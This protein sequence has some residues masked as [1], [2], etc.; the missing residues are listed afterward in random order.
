MKFD[1]RF[2]QH[3][4]KFK[5]FDQNNFFDDK[6]R[7]IEVLES[8]THNH[9]SGP[10]F[11]N[12]KVK[13]EDTVWAG[14][15][16]VH[17]NSSD[18]KK[19][20]HHNDK[21]YDNVI[22][23]VVYKNDCQVIRT[24]GQEIPTAELKIQ[25]RLMNDYDSLIQS[26]RQIACSDSILAV[27]NFVINS[28]LS[29]VLFERMQAKTDL[30][31]LI[32]EQNKNDWEEAFYTMTARAFGF[33]VNADPFELLSKSVSQKILSK[34]KNSVFQIEALL[35]GQSGFLEKDIT[36]DQYFKD[37]QKEYKFLRAKYNLK[38]IEE[39]L[40]KFMRLRPQNF[41]TLRISQFADL[42]SKSSHLFSKIIENNNLEEIKVLFNAT[43]SDYWTNHFTFGH[44][45]A[46]KQ[47][48]VGEEAVENI[49]IN[50]VI[51]FLFIYGKSKDDDNIKDKALTFLEQ[52]KAEN[53][54][55][56]RN[57]KEIGFNA[58]NAMF[59]QAL[60]HL[61]NEY[62]SKKRC[63]ECRIGINLIKF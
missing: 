27:D 35:F 11:F 45:S 29:S 34:H 9:N 41:P 3:V 51:P 54:S 13:I 21:A 32:L 46:G 61:N 22:L 4:W 37:L 25:D 47:K 16:E 6:G 28:W 24:N 62:C 38:P 17:V 55:V 23:Q 63:I 5:L 33:K 58:P 18:W 53:N 19:H 30:V 42:I 44:E 50:T 2:L 10:D 36:E 7:K 1:E 59:S 12:A 57:W 52:M 39:H 26:D 49:I 8:G 48:I 15:V 20:S 40:W 56:I 31:N 14:N 43:A 60:I